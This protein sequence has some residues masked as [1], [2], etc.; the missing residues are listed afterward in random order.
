MH[1]N[2]FADAFIAQTKQP[3]SVYIKYFIDL[4]HMFIC[5]GIVYKQ[6]ADRIPKKVIRIIGNISEKGKS[7]YRQ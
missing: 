2:R 4:V 1:H 6:F 5:Y 3:A 7:Y